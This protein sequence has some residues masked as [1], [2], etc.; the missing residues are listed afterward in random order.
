MA[1]TLVHLRAAVRC[2]TR[3]CL[4]VAALP[5]SAAAEPATNPAA[6]HAVIVAGQPGTAWHAARFADWAARFRAHLSERARVPAANITLLAAADGK[7]NPAQPAATAAGV[8]AAISNVA[9]RVAPQD[10]FVLLLAGHGAAT[11]GDPTFSLPGDDL[12]LPQ[13][14]EAL[15]AVPSREQIILHLGSAAGDCVPALAAPGRVVVAASSAGEAAEPVFGE[16]LLLALER[17][18]AANGRPTVL[19]L[20][21]AAAGETSQWIRRIRGTEAGWAVDGRESVRIFRKLYGG[22]SPANG[23]RVL[24]PSSQEQVED[25]PVP[26]AM[27]SDGS[28]PPGRRVVDE[29]AIL[30]DT[31]TGTGLAAVA[32][33]GFKPIAATKPGE[34]G[35]VAATRVIGFPSGTTGRG[36]AAP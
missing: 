17:K 24:D 19:D 26:P 21:N 1:H 31:G 13:L 36:A 27:P 23:G 8:L 2:T 5:L 34:P 29:H 4:T 16:F 33:T 25:A 3:L 14:V 10:Q 12:R 11:D 9:A 28:A 15:A 35:F 22:S 6:C 18:S 32:P 30:D 7:G 20:F